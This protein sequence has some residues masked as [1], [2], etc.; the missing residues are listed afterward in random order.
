MA[1]FNLGVAYADGRGVEKDEAAAV[2]W[3]RKAA[4][5]GDVEAKRALDIINNRH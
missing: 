1:Q 2:V 4:D 3:F 5:Q